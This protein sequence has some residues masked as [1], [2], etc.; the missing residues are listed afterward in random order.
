MPAALFAQSAIAGAVKEGAGAPVAVVAVETSSGA[1]IG[2]SPSAVTDGNG[3]Y[4]IEE[5][6]PRTY[7]VS[8][9]LSGWRPYRQDGVE[10]TGSLTA[11]VN[12]ELTLG[13]LTDS[14]T[15]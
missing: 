3:R 14:V 8:F 5:L 1:L 11:T 7:S 15:V 2:Q 12:A 4:R 6:R 9:V 10:V 13:A